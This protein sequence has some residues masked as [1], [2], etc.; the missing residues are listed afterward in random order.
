MKACWSC[1]PPRGWARG[2]E[3]SGR[4]CLS[5]LP[6]Q[7]C[8]DDGTGKSLPSLQIPK[9]Y[10]SSGKHLPGTVALAG[11]RQLPHVTSVQGYVIKEI[12]ENAWGIFF[13]PCLLSAHLEHYWDN[14]RRYLPGPPAFSFSTLEGLIS[15]KQTSPYPSMSPLQQPPGPKVLNMVLWDGSRRTLCSATPA[16]PSL[17]L[18][19]VWGRDRLTE[20]VTHRGDC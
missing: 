18:L 1:W 13:Y 7:A 16:F 14:C 3:R 11:N 15:Q 2:R 5:G 4:C 6:E 19:G 10:F 8:W 17:L 9:L 12:W 20:T